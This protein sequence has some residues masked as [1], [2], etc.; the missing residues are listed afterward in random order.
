VARGTKAEMRPGVWRLRVF[1]GTDPTSGNPRQ[2]SRTVRGGVRTAERELARFV[3]ESEAGDVPMGAD[4]TVAEFLDAWLA[5]VEPQRSPTTV[6]GY[7]DKARRW[8][9]ALGSMRVRRLTAQDLDRT[10]A[11]WLAEGA[12]PMTVRHCHRILAAA[13]KQGQRWG[14]VTRCVTDLARPPA[15]PAHPPPD[16]DPEVWE[17]MVFDLREREPVTA[18]A[19]LLAGVTGARRGELCGLRWTD[20]DATR[21]LLRIARSIQ[22]GLDKTTL[23]VAP[24]KTGRE[25]RVALDARTLALLA[26]YRR[27]AEQWA[28]QARVA[29]AH[30]GYIL[31]LDP[32]GSTPLK[33][34]RPGSP[35]RP[36]GWERESGFTTCDI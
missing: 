21:R 2:L 29:L 27:Q 35:G 24:T 18:M 8:K 16:V 28:A 12:A 10:Y 22:H 36:G 7:R 6:R 13:L 3:T 34:S 25:R 9:A 1:V 4:Q 30:D 20:I 5:F 14:L 19:A 26:D 33:P 32:T 15:T 23:V 17:A 11:R 31:T